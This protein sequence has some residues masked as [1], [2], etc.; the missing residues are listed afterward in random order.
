MTTDLTVQRQGDLL[1]SSTRPERPTLERAVRLATGLVALYPST[2]KIDEMYV[3]GVAAIFAAY[4]AD[5]A[6]EVVNPLTGLPSRSKFLPSIAEIKEA[7]EA[8][9][10]PPPSPN[11]AIINHLEFLRIEQLKERLDAEQWERD[12]PVARRRDVVEKLWR[13]GLREQMREGLPEHKGWRERG[14]GFLQQN[15][16]AEQLMNMGIFDP[17]NGEA[18][19]E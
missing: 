16:P 7:L 15:T 3:K 10:P 12:N 19:W 1:T 14:K 5:W 13:K 17:K 6:H 8:M 4:P 18:R 9:G 11:E 2:A